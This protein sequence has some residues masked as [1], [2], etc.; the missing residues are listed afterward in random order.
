MILLTGQLPVTVTT[1]ASLKSALRTEN[2]GGA[3]IPFG[4]NNKVNPTVNGGL[5]LP[6]LVS[7]I[8]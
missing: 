3:E 1:G 4:G 8:G 6:S 7:V 5:G 2:L